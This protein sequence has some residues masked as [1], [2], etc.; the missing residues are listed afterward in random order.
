MAVEPSSNE[1]LY[2]EP[3]WLDT[4]HGACPV[5]CRVCSPGLF[6]RFGM[7]DEVVVTEDTAGCGMLLLPKRREGQ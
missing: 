6:G 2:S 7:D 4:E 3:V 1:G 5:H